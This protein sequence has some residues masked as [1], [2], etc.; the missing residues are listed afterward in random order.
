[1]KLAIYGCSHTGSGPIKWNETW[2]YHLYKS[3]KIDI[4][5]FAIGASSTQ[6]QYDLFKNNI[7]NF[8]KFI[9]QFTSPYRLTKYINPI[10]Q[11]KVKKYSF[12]PNHS[13]DKPMEFRTSINLESSTPGKY[14]KEY[15]RWIANDNGEILEEYKKI[16][17]VVNN[18]ENCLYA[19]HWIEN[20]T[21][22]QGIDIMQNNF[23]DIILNPG[24][25]LDSE[26][27]QIIAMYIKERCKL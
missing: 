23:P 18:H 1:M 7:N 8:D 11:T 6:F 12:F 9:F 17:T 25:H 19:F 14:N 26:E 3:T 22:V 13:N 24:I 20:Y 21:N 16:C 2:P 10:Q 4:S 5:N 27:N 15:K